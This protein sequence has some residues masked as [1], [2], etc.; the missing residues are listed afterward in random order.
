MSTD[1]DSLTREEVGRLI[2]YS[3]QLGY[4][5]IFDDEGKER[6]VP[7]NPKLQEIFERTL[8]NLRCR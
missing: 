4:R 6:V 1:P 7:I 5:I 8:W 3:D 2:A